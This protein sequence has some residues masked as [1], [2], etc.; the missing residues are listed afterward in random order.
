MKTPSEEQLINIL[1][2]IHETRPY[3]AFYILHYDAKARPIESH[4]RLVEALFRM[5][6]PKDV[7]V[8]SYDADERSLTIVGGP[9]KFSRYGSYKGFTIHYLSSF[10][11]KKLLISDHPKH[12]LER[13][14]LAPTI[15]TE[16]FFLKK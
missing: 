7:E 1:E 15:E 8:F 5:R 4:A 3:L 6:N 12:H 9:Y 16:V 10:S 13:A 14:K 11:I 2:G